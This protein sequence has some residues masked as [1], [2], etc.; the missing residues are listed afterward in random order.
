MRETPRSSPSLNE[1]KPEGSHTKNKKKLKGVIKKM[2][3]L[4]ANMKG[5]KTTSIYS[6]EGKSKKQSIKSRSEKKTDKKSRS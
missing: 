2:L 1:E 3:M 4:K 5:E 6:M